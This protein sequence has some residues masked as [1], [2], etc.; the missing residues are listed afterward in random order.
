MP[1]SPR[2]TRLVKSYAPIVNSLTVELGIDKIE[3]KPLKIYC[4]EKKQFLNSDEFYV[5]KYHQ[6]KDPRTLGAGNFRHISK[7]IWDQR[8]KNNKLG[9]GWKS[10]EELLIQNATLEEFIGAI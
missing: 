2:F 4:K 7:E 10:D 1:Y 3:T 5:K 9:L 6:D 8:V